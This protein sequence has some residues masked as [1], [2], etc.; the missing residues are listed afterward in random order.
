MRPRVPSVATSDP[1]LPSAARGI[2]SGQSAHWIPGD[3]FET[4]AHCLSVPGSPKLPEVSVTTPQL[5]VQGSGSLLLS[6]SS[7]PYFSLSLCMVPN[8]LSLPH[9]FL[10]P[11]GPNL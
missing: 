5:P 1:A 2:V 10:F 4:G 11:G 9:S 6:P 8:L 7:D 3:L